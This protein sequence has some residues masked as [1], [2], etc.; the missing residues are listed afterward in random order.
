MLWG[1]DRMV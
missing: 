1:C